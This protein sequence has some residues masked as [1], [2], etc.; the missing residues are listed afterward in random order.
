MLL[1]YL[2]WDPIRR[3]L[4]FGS[5]LFVTLLAGLSMLL[6]VFDDYKLHMRRLRVVNAMTSSITRAHQQGPMMATALEELKKLMSAKAAW[7]RLLDGDKMV[8]PTILAFPKRFCAN[9][10]RW[11]RMT[12][13]SRLSMLLR[14]L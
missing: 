5:G 10:S 12:T 11:Q 1:L 3:Y 2:P 4:P 9:G 14:R 6:L 7:F 8:F 13:S